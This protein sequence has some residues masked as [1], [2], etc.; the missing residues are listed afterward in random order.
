MRL[1]TPD[2]Y[3]LLFV[4]Q[5]VTKHKCQKNQE[6]AETHWSCFHTPQ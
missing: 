5:T 2:Q 4:D 1:Q 3:F 6:P